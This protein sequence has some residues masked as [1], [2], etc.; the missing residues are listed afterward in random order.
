MGDIS[1]LDEDGYFDMDA[2]SA[3]EGTDFRTLEAGALISRFRGSVS[4]IKQGQSGILQV[5][6]NIESK[7]KFEALKMA[8]HPGLSLA[9]ECRRKDPSRHADEQ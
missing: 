6:L 5:T 8:A 1:Y 3:P 7:D 2:L 4:N 9:F